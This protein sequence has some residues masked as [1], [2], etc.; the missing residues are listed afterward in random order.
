MY[1]FL[2]KDKRHKWR[3]NSIGLNLEEFEFLLKFKYEGNYNKG[4][5]NFCLEDEDFK[6]QPIL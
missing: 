3:Q 4:K 5:W 1:L 6:N 2:F